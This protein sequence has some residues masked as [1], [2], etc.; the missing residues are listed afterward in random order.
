MTSF[1]AT[2][3]C[4]VGFVVTAILRAL[5]EECVEIS[6]TAKTSQIMENM[7]ESTPISEENQCPSSFKN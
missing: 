2:A 6:C 7:A 5:L 3:H 1:T 4:I